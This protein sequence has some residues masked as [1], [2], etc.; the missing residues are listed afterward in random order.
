MLDKLDALLRAGIKV[1]RV[2][3]A[4]ADAVIRR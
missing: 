4:V 1:A 2:L 3:I